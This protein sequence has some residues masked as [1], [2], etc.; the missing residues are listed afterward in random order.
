[1]TPD[2][3][4]AQRF[5]ALVELPDEL[6]VSRL[7]E[8]ALLIAA[9]LQPGLDIEKY[10]TRLDEIAGATPDATL[11][12]VT[13]HLFHTEGFRGNSDDYYDPRNSYLDH[14]L[15]S[16]E[17]IPITLGVVLMEVVRRLG[18]SLRGV[19]MP[20]HFLVRL[21]SEIPLFVDPFEGGRLLAPTE[22]E[23]LFRGVHGVDAQFD[24]SYLDAVDSHAILARMLANLRTIFLSRQD[25]RA[26]AAVLTLRNAI[27]G[28][29]IEEQLELAGVLVALSRFGEAATVIEALAP[30]SRTSEGRSSLQG[31]AAR[32]RA[33]LN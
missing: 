29:P 7:D 19:G 25:S 4:P 22:C 23:Q 18:I 24:P 27:P 13:E 2:A 11:A 28:I 8:A 16:R 10:I 1:M 3:T 17:G 31:K 9:A 20:G 12:A 15:D 21:D 33:R 6:L 14:V 30:R 26:L 32:L 5:A